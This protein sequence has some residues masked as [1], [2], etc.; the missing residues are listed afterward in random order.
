MS[1]PTLT[2]DMSRR[3][4]TTEPGWPTGTAVALAQQRDAPVWGAV[5]QGTPDPVG[6]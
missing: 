1:G 3:I 6:G 2:V 5:F 4:H